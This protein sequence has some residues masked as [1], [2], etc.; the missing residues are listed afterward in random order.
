MRQ[1]KFAVIL[2]LLCLFAVT[3]LDAQVA[4]PTATPAAVPMPLLRYVTR[5]AQVALGTRAP[6]DAWG[7]AAFRTRSSALDC[8]FY[9]GSDL[10]VE[11]VAYDFSLWLNN[12]EY[13]VRSS[14]DGSIIVLC[15]ERML[16]TPTVTPTSTPIGTPAPTATQTPRCLIAPNG[17]L[18]NV[19]SEPS[20]NGG[21][22]T[23]LAQIN[24]STPAVARTE[25]G[26][27]FRVEQGWVAASVISTIGD[28]A[29]L[30]VLEP[31]A[32]DRDALSTAVF[33]AANG[34]PTRSAT[35]TLT[36]SG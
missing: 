33:S 11:I 26:A 32:D 20:T 7:F 24:F 18:A 12:V 3:A 35:P 2:V 15:D 28:C 14:A 30:P 17:G 6:L 5:A 10:G 9:T 34:T 8:P 29:G 19:R 27:W 16:Q 4:P 36:P 22:F 1:T 13:E 31:D 21:N 25:D 23:I